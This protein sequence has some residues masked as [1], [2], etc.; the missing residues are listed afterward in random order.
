MLNSVFIKIFCGFVFWAISID[1]VAKES[2]PVLKIG[3]SDIDNYPTQYL[4]E[5]QLA[6]F[7]FEMV[8][9]IADNMGYDIEV[10]RM[11]FKRL[12]KMVEKHK[13]D[14]IVFSQG[15]AKEHP[16]LHFYRGSTVFGNALSITPYF[17]MI[18]KD[19]KDIR[20]RGDLASLHHLKLGFKRNLSAINFGALKTAL[21]TANALE[22]ESHQQLEKLILKDRIDAAIVP[23]S[24]FHRYKSGKLSDFKIFTRPLII[25]YMSVVFS[26][27][28]TE[29]EFVIKFSDELVNYQNSLSYLK[30]LKF[31]NSISEMAE[32]V[33]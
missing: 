2:R 24:V 31:Y 33:P 28:S 30:R 13:I 20:F 11:P 7:H 22:L 1:L 18:K 16:L 25:D 29:R 5:G 14:A 8:T 4:Q 27:K 32:Y 3:F 12:L 19:R 21:L 10:Y 23:L 6:G 9:E 26:K 17:L 15:A